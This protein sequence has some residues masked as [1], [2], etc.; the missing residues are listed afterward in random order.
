VGGRIIGEPFYI[1]ASRKW[2]GVQG[3]RS[4]VRGQKSDAEVQAASLTSEL[5]PL[6]SCLPTGVI[7]GTAT[8]T[9]CQRLTSDLCP[10]TSARY[11]RHLK[12]VK[13]LSKRPRRQPRRMPQPVWFRP[14]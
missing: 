9:R 3:Q 11:E 6:T 7:V 4:E 5:C 13:R 10:L 12:D 1:Y 14:F 8:I 2:A